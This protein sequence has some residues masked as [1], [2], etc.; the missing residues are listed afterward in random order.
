[1]LHD[2]RADPVVT[3]TSVSE[4]MSDVKWL[5]ATTILTAT[6]KGNLKLFQFDEAAKS[7]KH[8]GQRTNTRRA[9]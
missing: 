8:V 6:G 7:L 2:A 3:Y 4:H 9:R 1:M 5:N